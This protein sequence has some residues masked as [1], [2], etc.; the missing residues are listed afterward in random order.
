MSFHLSALTDDVV[1]L[2]VPYKGKEVVHRYEDAQTKTISFKY[3]AQP[4]TVRIRSGRITYLHGTGI[5]HLLSGYLLLSYTSQSSYE[6]EHDSVKFC[7]KLLSF[8]NSCRD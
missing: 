5:F 6:L 1:V 7:R 8:N 3:R 2:L 4:Y